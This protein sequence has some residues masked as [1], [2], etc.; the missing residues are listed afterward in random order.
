MYVYTCLYTTLPTQTVT[1]RCI[2]TIANAHGGESVSNVMF[3][4]SS[5]YLLSSGADDSCRCV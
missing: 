4:P 2:N 3:S 1:N 5:R